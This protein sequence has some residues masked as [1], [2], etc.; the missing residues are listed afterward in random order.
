MRRLWPR[1]R[2][3]LSAVSSLAATTAGPKE[4]TSAWQAFPLTSTSQPRAVSYAATQAATPACIK[5]RTQPPMVR[6]TL[7]VVQR[8][9]LL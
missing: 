6:R 3:L 2:L 4:P 8:Q 9:R 1:A 5:P 7:E